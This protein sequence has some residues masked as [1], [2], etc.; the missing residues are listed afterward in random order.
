M[1]K[2]NGDG[3]PIS[4]TL[5]NVTR[6]VVQDFRIVSPPFWANA[7]VD[8]SDVVYD[9]MYVNASNANPA[10]TDRKW[11]FVISP[12]TKCFADAK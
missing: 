10:W 9:G 8:S 11:V 12:A 5:S 4:F 2:E 7:V 6:G 3:R 1:T